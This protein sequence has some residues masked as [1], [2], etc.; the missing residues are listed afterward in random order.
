[1]EKD[2]EKL[3]ELDFVS[4][5]YILIKRRKIIFYFTGIVF[6]VTL[7][8]VLIINRYYEANVMV[9]PSKQKNQFNAASFLKNALPLGGLGL[10]KTSDELLTY[11]TILNSRSSSDQIIGKFNLMKV[12][13]L[14]SIDKTIKKLNENIEFVINDDETAL[15]IK[16]FDVDSTRAKEM[17]SFAIEILNDIYIKL[18]SIEAKNNREFIQKRYEQTLFDLQNTEDSLRRFQEKFGI[19]TTTDQIKASIVAAAELKSKIVLSE[20]Q[21]G[22][23]EKTLSKDNLEVSNLKIQIRELERQYSNL[24]KK[25]SNND[26]SDVFIPL[27]KIPQ[28]GLQYIRLLRDIE[29]QSRIQET[30]LPL[31][32][33]AKIE[34]NRDTPTVVVLDN[35]YVS[36]RP[37][38]PRRLIILV[39]VTLG[40]LLASI[41]IVFGFEFF[42]RIKNGEEYKNEK[43][44]YIKTTLRPKNLFKF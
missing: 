20:I 19:Y 38:K 42:E 5:L 25:E 43:I 3:Y 2:T 15:T 8:T 37:V 10:A 21:L 13:D 4:F 35:A 31:F 23:L 22:V 32:E 26:Q 41:F 40:S 11:T 28:R 18:N 7:V 27:S 33:Q 24:I 1:M 6:F 29:I 30:L 36:D 44:N 14:E 9:M 12:Y 16:V 17:A 34:E 39:V